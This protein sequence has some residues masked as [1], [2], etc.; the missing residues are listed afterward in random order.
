MNTWII[1][2]YE[3]YSEAIVNIGPV[4]I[5]RWFQ[6]MAGKKSMLANS[7]GGPAGIRFNMSRQVKM[8]VH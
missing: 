3:N 1:L 6:P 5:E 7:I 4:R 8:T 2:M